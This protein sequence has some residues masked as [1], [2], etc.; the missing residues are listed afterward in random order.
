MRSWFLIVL[1]CALCA[2]A[3]PALA[4]DDHGAGG[5]VKHVGVE[6]GLFKGAIE[7]SLWTILVFLI[8][9]T[10][11]RKYAWTPIAEG[12]D[13]REQ[14]IAHDKQEAVKA[15]Q[16]AE[17]LRAQL[18][19]EMAKVNDQIRIMMDKARADAAQTTA[20]ELA[21][22]KLELAAER[23]RMRRE[24]QIST[25]DALHQ[26]WDQSA[27]LATMIS[28]KAIHKQ[29]NYDDHRVLVGEALAEFRQAAE[30][31]KLDIES[32]RA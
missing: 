9:L 21:R 6:Q 4:A 31:R 11:L 3:S 28:S 1:L 10:V 20:E 18:A 12:L 16:E 8:L 27:R 14:S 15:K 32:A 25:D 13:K 19:A 24:L 29:L 26:M 22:G 2:V 30:G 5:K 17:A 7:V 23:D